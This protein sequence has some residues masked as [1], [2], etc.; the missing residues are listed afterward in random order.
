MTSIIVKESQGVARLSLNRPPHNLLTKEVLEEIAASF[1]GFTKSNVATGSPHVVVI[2]SAI[3]NTFS[4]G[5]DPAVFVKGTDEYREDVFLR[6]ADMIEAMYLG[7]IPIVGD[8]CGNAMAGGAVIAGLCD[9]VVMSES[10]KISYS[11]VKVGMPIPAFMMMTL[12]AKV[13]P[14][15]LFELAYLGKNFNAAEAMDVGLAHASYKTSEERDEKLK[16]IVGRIMRIK[17]EVLRATLLDAR[18][19]FKP[20]VDDFRNHYAERFAPFLGEKFL[21]AGLKGLLK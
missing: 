5:M 3:A 8:V 11:E 13:S 14:R 10:A 2:D 7:G 19:E 1:R 20:L 18:R 12:K 15:A 6:L 9:Y 17:P 16:G 21:L 4:I